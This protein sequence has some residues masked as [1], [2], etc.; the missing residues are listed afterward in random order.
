MSKQHAL[1]VLQP[2]IPRGMA[3]LRVVVQT[4]LSYENGASNCEQ[5]AWQQ[6][7]MHVLHLS[8]LRDVRVSFNLLNFQFFAPRPKKQCRWEAND[9]ICGIMSA[10]DNHYGMFK[11]L[12]TDPMTPIL[13]SFPMTLRRKKTA[14][15]N[16]CGIF[17]PL[18][19]QPKTTI[20]ICS[21]KLRKH[22]L[23]GG[24]HNS[25]LPPTIRVIGHCRPILHETLM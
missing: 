22:T 13:L 4:F 20:V 6:G 3:R 7:K 5:E 12:W 21:K 15:D 16:Y 14:K 24:S 8:L 11:L 17:L 23:L 9:T 19:A 10:M 25:C 18:C 2:Q 1:A